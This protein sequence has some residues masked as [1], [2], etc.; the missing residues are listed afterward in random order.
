VEEPL[1]GRGLGIGINEGEVVA[2]NIG[3]AS[4]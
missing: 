1:P 2:G 4:Y 3:S